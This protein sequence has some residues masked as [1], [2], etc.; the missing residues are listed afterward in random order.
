MPEPKLVQCA[1]CGLDVYEQKAKSGAIYYTNSELRGKTARGRQNWH[2]DTCTEK[3][4]TVT[5]KP[6]PPVE[7]DHSAGYEQDDKDY[8]AYL[9]MQKEEAKKAAEEKSTENIEF[10]PAD[11]L[12]KFERTYK[13]IEVTLSKACRVN[14]KTIP[15][16]G[17]FEH[18]D[19]F[20]NMKIQVEI[21]NEFHQLARMKFAEMQAAID[22]EITMDRLRLSGLEKTD[23]E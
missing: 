11:S 8:Q 13:V 19:Y 2:S 22:K 10:K 23:D 15:Q 21:N 5:Q 18:K 4:S 9:A 12:Y 6:S 1:K 3:K 17:D 16:L 7:E 14:K 20:A